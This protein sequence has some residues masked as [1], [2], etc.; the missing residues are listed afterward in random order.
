MYVI[1]RES[2]SSGEDTREQQEFNFAQGQV[3][4]LHVHDGGVRGDAEGRGDVGGGQVRQAHRAVV[5]WPCAVLHF[6]KP[7]IGN[8][9]THS[10]GY[11]LSFSA[12]SCKELFTLV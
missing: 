10:N 6:L 7:S 1:T 5:L 9:H 2:L 12:G 4:R 11:G 3:A 8:Q